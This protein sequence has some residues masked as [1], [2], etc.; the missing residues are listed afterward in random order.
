MQVRKHVYHQCLD[1]N[2]C[3]QRTRFRGFDQRAQL[4][5]GRWFLE[6]DEAEQI[7]LEVR[8]GGRFYAYT[9]GQ[10]DKEGTLL[11][12]IIALKE[13]DLITLQGPFGMRAW[14]V[15]V[16]SNSLYRIPSLAH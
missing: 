11:G 9:G 6:F 13:P 2:P 5:V 8:L 1:D 4:L 16:Q 15:M 12:I 14:A 10:S 3:A 7:N